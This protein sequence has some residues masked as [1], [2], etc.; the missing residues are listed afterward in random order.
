M[1]LAPIAL[2]V[3]NRPEL[4]RFTLESLNKNE[5][6]QESE[7]FIYSDG[8]KKNSDAEKIAEVRKI[9]REKNWCGKVHII[10]S[11][12]NKGLAISVIDGVTEIVN[13]FGKIIV[14]ED[15]MITSL[16]FL[17]FMNEALEFYKNTEE[18]ISIH[19]YLFPV[20]KKL[21]N[22]FFLKGADCWGWATWK[23]GWDLFEPDGKKLMH[24]I[25]N[26]KLEYQFD[27]SGTYPYLKMLKKQIAGRNDSWAIRWYASAFL[28][29]KLTLYPGKS[30]ILNTGTAGKGTHVHKVKWFKTE[31]ADA[32]VSI[33]KISVEVNRVAYEAFRNYFLSIKPNLL[34]K[35]LF[36]LQK[37]N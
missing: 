37:I 10:E 34:Q 2:F 19:G 11:A 25:Q 28:K 23:R 5:G 8:A 6:A 20:E 9:I 32:P 17:K 26:K 12:T 27:F 29:N 35:I 16:Y 33:E 4:T 24:E 7:L 36:T 15:D 31:L 14:L 1:S 13:K 22:T 30:H 21:P 18:V 3:Y